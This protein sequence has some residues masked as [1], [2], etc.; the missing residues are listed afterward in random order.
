MLCGCSLEHLHLWPGCD[1]SRGGS[2]RTCFCQGSPGAAGWPRPEET[3]LWLPTLHQKRQQ[4]S[5]HRR[6]PGVVQPLPKCI[7]S[8]CFFIVSVSICLPVT[9]RGARI[10]GFPEGRSGRGAAPQA[11]PQAAAFQ[12]GL[13]GSTAPFPL[14]HPE[15]GGAARGQRGSGVP[16]QRAAA[17]AGSVR[18]QPPSLQ[19]P[20]KFT[21]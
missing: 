18:R 4:P 3:S 6:G 7:F 21:A 12:Q 16:P 9:E 2:T 13:A 10:R 1:R 15:L 5:W 8:L 19:S 14:S 11:V 20:Y 17:H